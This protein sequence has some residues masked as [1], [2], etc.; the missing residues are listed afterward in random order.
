MRSNKFW[1]LILGGAVLASA[2]VSLLLMQAPVG[3]ARIYKEGML[4]EAVNL[5][6]ITEPYTIT[7]D[8]SIDARD[9]SIGNFNLLEV[10]RGRIRMQK[11]DCPDGSCIRQGWVSGGVVP[12]VCLPN[13]L[14][15]TFESY[16]G[17][18]GVDAVVG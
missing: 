1:I 18:S 16:N 7:I 10:E 17:D 3:H 2:I 6:A 15:V 12:I 13:R 4:I 14:V 11:A 9:M 8:G 5:V